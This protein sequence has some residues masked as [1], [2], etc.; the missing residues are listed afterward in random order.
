MVNTLLTS[1]MEISKKNDLLDNYPRP[2]NCSLNSPRV[3]DVIWDLCIDSFGR[4]L[5]VKLQSIQ[6]LL[7]KGLT[8]I[9]AAANSLLT[10][11]HKDDNQQFVE[12]LL[13]SVLDGIALISSSSYSLSTYRRTNL[14]QFLNEKYSSLCSSKTPV[15]DMLFGDNV[16][17]KIDSLTKG[18]KAAALV[19]GS[20]QGSG[21]SR[22]RGDFRGRRR[23]GRGN[24][25]S[26][27]GRFLGRRG[28]DR[29]GRKY[30]SSQRSQRNYSQKEKQGRKG[31]DT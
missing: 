13:N 1:P 28:S 25:R 19:T 5:D 18:Q 12:A 17:D 31:K 16:C 21:S 14:K 27:R 11:D 3:N 7:L 20:D 23:G 26:G 8:P 22:F 2:E 6:K 29:G 15:T 24:F 10:A 9:V 30:Y 4:S